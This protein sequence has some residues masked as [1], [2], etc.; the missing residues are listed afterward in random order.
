MDTL[1]V[2]PC[3]ACRRHI[4]RDADACP[5][6]DAPHVALPI[7]FTPVARARG[8]LAGGAMLLAAACGPSGD[9]SGDTGDGDTGGG[10]DTSGGGDTGSGL[11]VG[12][13]GEQSCA[14]RCGSHHQAQCDEN[15]ENCVAPPYGAPAIDDLV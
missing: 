14:G 15:G 6:C 10:E 5:F 11:G 1:L 2:E 9:S 4:R 7:R 12:N 8:A 3:V 13:D